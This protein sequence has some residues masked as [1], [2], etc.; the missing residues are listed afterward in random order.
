[1]DPTLFPP[2]TG[3]ESLCRVNGRSLLKRPEWSWSN[4]HADGHMDRHV[5]DFWK[6][7]M[8]YES[9]NGDEGEGDEMS[10]DGRRR[11]LHNL[12]FLRWDGGRRWVWRR[13]RERREGWKSERAD[14]GTFLKVSQVFERYMEDKGKRKKRSPLTLIYGA[15]LICDATLNKHY[16]TSV[17]WHQGV[18][19]SGRNGRK[20][21]QINKAEG[22]RNGRYCAVEE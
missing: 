13:P 2:L 3:R 21:G 17:R 18:S 5:V 8:Y 10:T 20:I 12:W 19:K 14:D 4:H 9:Y 11:C 1:M 22:D 15:F 6:I 7:C 16:Q